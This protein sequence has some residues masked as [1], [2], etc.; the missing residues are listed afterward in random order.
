V[1]EVGVDIPEA[2]FLIINNPERFGL[3]QLH[4]LRGRIGRSGGGGECYLIVGEDIGTSSLK[5]LNY[6]AGTN[7]GFEVAERDLEIRG[8]GE[9]WGVRQSG[10]PVF[11][12]LN[13]ISDNALVQASWKE[14]ERL[15]S[16]DPT[17]GKKENLFVA[18]YLRHYY[19]PRMEIAEIG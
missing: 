18:H 19:E 7:D 13:P 16:S 10:K 11:R 6:F 3:A 5:R 8:P 9:I 1:I 15:I 14:S 17:L 4:Q 2:S 12:L